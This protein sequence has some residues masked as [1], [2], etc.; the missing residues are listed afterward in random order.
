MRPVSPLPPLPA[1]LLLV[2]EVVFLM[3]VLTD[4]GDVCVWRM[5]LPGRSRPCVILIDS[6]YISYQS[7]VLHTT[8]S[9]HMLR[10]RSSS[11]HTPSHARRNTCR[12]ISGSLSA[13]HSHSSR[14]SGLPFGSE[15]QLRS[16]ASVGGTKECQAPAA[17][18]NSVWL[19][20]DLEEN[21]RAHGPPLPFELF[22]LLV[23]GLVL[24]AFVGKVTSGY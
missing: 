22:E 17:S 19:S 16:S 3:L 8:P 7:S 6:T 11:G 13:S 5:L 9:V 14:T 15:Y 2:M 18:M 24:S 10:V 21:E 20:I 4:G 12:S 1:L 23:V